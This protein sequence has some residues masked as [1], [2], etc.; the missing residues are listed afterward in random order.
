MTQFYLHTNCTKPNAVGDNGESIHEMM[1]SLHLKE[2]S[3]A[4]FI[5]KYAKDRGIV[6]QALYLANWERSCDFKNDFGVSCYSGLFQGIPC[7]VLRASAIEYIFIDEEYGNLPLGKSG[8]AERA[9][10]A[11]KLRE[12]ILNDKSWEAIKTK[13]KRKIYL[14]AFAQ[15]NIA[16]FTKY[17][18]L[19]ENILENEDALSK[20]IVDI[21]ETIIL[22]ARGM[23]KI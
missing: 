16:T 6:K 21:D 17:N 15:A 9:E 20:A 2:I 11:E 18:L 10:Q 3:N 19:M 13:S 4:R 22:P 8:I 7:L 1:N 23:S 14:Q 5:S 12:L